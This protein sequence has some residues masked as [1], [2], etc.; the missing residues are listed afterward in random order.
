MPV[1]G[2]PAARLDKLE[3]S[4]GTLAVQLDPAAPGSDDV[5][6][7]LVRVHQ[8][9]GSQV[10]TPLL[11][12]AG[13]PGQSGVELATSSVVLLPDAL[14]D[15][16]DLV[17]FDPRGVGRSQ[18]ITCEHRAP[19]RPTF[20]DLLTD[21]GFRRTAQEIRTFADECASSLGASASLFSTTATATDI[22]H[23]RAAL[24]QPTLTYIGWSYGAKLG[25][26]YARLH[27]D[28]VRAAV[29]DAP[30]DPNISWTQTVEAQVAGFEST[31]DQFVTWCTDQGACSGLGDV[32]EFLRDLVDQALR[33]P[34]PSGRPGDV[35]AT[36]GVEVLDAVASA[37]YDDLRWPDLAAGLVE[38]SRGDSGT[39]RDLI[40]AARDPDDVHAGDAQFVINCNDSAPGPTE[41]AI[42]AAGRR[43][44]E[45]FPLF[46]LWGSSQLFGCA[47]WTPER[48]TLQPPAAATTTPVVVVGTRFDPATPYSGAESMASI[49]GNARLLTWEGNGHTAVGRN[50]CITDLVVDYLNTLALP[51]PTSSICP[52]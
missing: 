14:L 45:E 28:K 37:M 49:L 34:I 9:G 39:L 11:L 2:L 50:E 25:A 43:F 10:K 35:V 46:G 26:E 40:D 12:I 5:V 21:D 31:F 18:P 4:C 3:F 24:D 29:L 8:A 16:F 48:H 23:I 22:D 51:P 27:P 33:T 1:R 15:R 19:A 6:L 36:N 20:P 44:V 42:K 7:Q 52:A 41:A 17:G 13:G 47:Y 32:E 38:A 30:T